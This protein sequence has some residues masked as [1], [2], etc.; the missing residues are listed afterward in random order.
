MFLFF[1][2]RLLD[3]PRKIT[4]AKTTASEDNGS[5]IFW[6]S[7]AAAAKPTASEDNGGKITASEDNRSGIF[8]NS[9]AAAEKPTASEDNG[10][11]NQRPRKITDWGYFE[12]QRRRRQN[13]RPRKITAA[14]TTA[15]E[16]N[17][18]GTNFQALE[19]VISYAEHPI[20]AE[21]LLPNSKY[22]APLFDGLEAQRTA[23]NTIPPQCQ[24]KMSW[25][26]IILSELLLLEF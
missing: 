7:K 2:F 25:N 20:H 17:G 16:D 5:G 11:K 23:S 3:G 21:N 15:S 8:W 18:S 22:D 6:N 24:N 10:G 12:I 13:Q 26:M 14:K 4:V 19:F 9:K 1:I